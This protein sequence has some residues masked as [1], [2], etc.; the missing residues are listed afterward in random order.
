MEIIVGAKLQGIMEAYNIFVDGE[1]VAKVR[2]N[3]MTTLKVTDEEH[4]VQLK[5][6]NGKSSIIKI[7][8]PELANEKV[9]LKFNTNYGKAFK[10]GYFELMEE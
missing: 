2:G 7:S 3:K 10:E 8:K 1:K 4:Q 5:G 6:A 9:T